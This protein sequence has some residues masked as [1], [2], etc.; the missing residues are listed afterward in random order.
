MWKR[1][2]TAVFVGCFLF[3][4]A[5]NAW[6]S[7]ISWSIGPNVS[8]DAGMS[9]SG[10]QAFAG[11]TVWMVPLGSSTYT[12]FLYS[13]PNYSQGIYVPTIPASGDF[14]SQA[15]WLNPINGALGFN[16][17]Y[18]LEIRNASNQIVWTSATSP[19][20]ATLGLTGTAKEGAISLSWNAAPG[21]T[22]Y[23][24]YKNG[25]QIATGITSLS[26]TVTGLQGAQADTFTVAGD[27]AYGTGPFSNAVTLQAY[28]PVAL[29]ATGGQGVI[30]G[31]V[32]GGLAPYTVTAATYTW[33][34]PDVG[35][36]FS[37]P[38]SP[39]SYTVTA[40]DAEGFKSSVNVVVQQPVVPSPTGVTQ[41]GTPGG[42]GTIKW[43]PAPNAPPGT[44][45]TVS[46]NGAPVGSTSGSSYTVS[47]YNPN[48][49]YAV[50]ASAPGYTSGAPQT[51]YGHL[52][53]GFTPLNVV[54]N[55]AALIWGIGG[56]VLLMLALLVAP[57]LVALIRGALSRRSED[58]S[59]EAVRYPE[60]GE[61]GYSD[62]PTVS[63]EMEAW[64]PRVYEVDVTPYRPPAIP[65]DRFDH[66]DYGR[67]HDE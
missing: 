14:A 20:S 7:S 44:T 38:V 33:T 51:Q 45:Y 46:Q 32:S 30:T 27:N 48:A 1:W 50:G 56:F 63:M 21:A 34:V 65:E 19:P 28:A 9:I 62:G 23:V 43:T 55:A 31:S 64:P 8:G 3:C 60:V 41:S 4:G 2:A 24:V 11:D 59:E 53:L 67:D 6:A 39:G 29:A 52:G 47:N 66:Y 35:N 22:D 58:E 36:S 10:A 18:P 40:T 49:V 57:R 16:D 37:E 26:Y 54:I 12:N 13:N 25:K 61:Y 17:A 15:H 5:P 42:S